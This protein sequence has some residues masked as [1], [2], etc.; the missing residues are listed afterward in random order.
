MSAEHDHQKLKAAVSQKFVES[1]ERE[2]LLELLRSRLLETGWNDNLNSYCRDTMKTK[3]VE[4]VTMTELVEETSDHARGSFLFL[5]MA[6]ER[7]DT[8]SYLPPYL[9]QVTGNHVSLATVADNI[10]KE[11]LGQLKIFLD[12]NLKDE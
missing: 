8:R 5:L 2:R 1:G 7:R 11:L 10:K 9:F 4:N 12:E 3:G 6:S